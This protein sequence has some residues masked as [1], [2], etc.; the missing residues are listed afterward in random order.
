MAITYSWKVV[1][2]NTK[3][4]G[5]IENAVIQVYWVKKGVDDNGIEGECAGESKFNINEIVPEQFVPFE[6]LTEEIILGWILSTI[7]PA[8]HEGIDAQIQ[9]MIDSKADPIFDRG[10]PW[11]PPPPIP[12]P[13]A[14][15]PEF[16]PPA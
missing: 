5:E 10:L 2:M 9:K 12:A 1:R 13:P 4:D 7:N 11:E 16:I 15:E 8:Y 6:E 14:P 3:N